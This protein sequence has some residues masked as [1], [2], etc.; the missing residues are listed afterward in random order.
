[1]LPCNAS[2]SPAGSDPRLAKSAL[3][4]DPSLFFLVSRDLFGIEFAISIVPRT[5][6]QLLIGE[7]AFAAEVFPGPDATVGG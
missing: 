2:K 7:R 3:S 1:M 5:L 6:P 4:D